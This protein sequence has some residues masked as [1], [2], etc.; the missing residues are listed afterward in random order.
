MM[1]ESMLYGFIGGVLG[2][3]VC[4]FIAAKVREWWI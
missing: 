2:H 4:T 3:L 1:F